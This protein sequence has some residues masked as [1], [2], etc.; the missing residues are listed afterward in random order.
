MGK[1]TPTPTT[2][3]QVAN[4]ALLGRLRRGFLEVRMTR[5]YQDLRGQ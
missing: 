4:K 1:Y 2:V 3:R 5:D